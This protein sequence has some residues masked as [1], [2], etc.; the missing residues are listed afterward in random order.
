MD[1]F[2]QGAIGAAAAQAVFGKRLGRWA[3][4]IGWG[5]GMLADIDV[6]VSSSADP[7]LGW[8]FHRSV[9]H[10]LVFIPVGALL[11]TLPFLLAPSLRPRWK[12]V[13]AAAF[14]GYATHGLLDACTTYGTLLYWPFSRTRVSW[15]VISIVD[16][17]FTLLLFIGAVWSAM[18]RSAWPARAGMVCAG[19]YMA[20]CVHQHDRAT[21]AQAAIV[22]ARGHQVEVARV[23]PT[24]GQSLVFRSVYRTT[25]DVLYVDAIRVPFSGAPTM[26]QG[27]QV[28]VFDPAGEKWIERAADPERMRRDLARFAWFADGFWARAPARPELIGDMRITADPAGLEPLWG[29]S[30]YPEDP[31]PVRAESG[32]GVEALSVS[33]LWREIA[34][35]DPRHV[36]VPR[37]S[38]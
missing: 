4:P 26:R 2:T 20:L 3:M 25:G 34:G 22:A 19:A 13:Y 21:A 1:S 30:L 35:S 11:V 28:D 10:A 5:A 16:P 7:L 32:A 31:V 15:D 38:R 23:M 27:G 6:F 29:I 12:E 9:T 18:R 14:L 37:A 33:A 17:I 24:L 36:P 8:T